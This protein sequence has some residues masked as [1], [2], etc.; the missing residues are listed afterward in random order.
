MKHCY[1]LF[2][3]S[4]V[5]VA[6][7]TTFNTKENKRAER[8][9]SAL[10][11]WFVFQ[12]MYPGTTV[13]Y[14]AYQDAIQQATAMK[15]FSP[16]TA[17]IPW[18]FA[19]PTN[20]GGRI[21]DIE[22]HPSSQQV[23]YFG[24]ASGGVFKSTDGGTTFN[25]IFDQN[26][27]LS[28]G[29]IAI[30]NTDANTIYV[31]TGEANCGGGSTTYDGMGIFKSTDG[32]NT[33][34]NMGLAQVR[35]VGRIA[36]N[37]KDKNTVY[38]AAMG[39]LYGKTPD[40]GVYKSTDGGNT[41]NNVLFINDSTGAVDIAVNPANPDTVF[42]AT[43][44]RVRTPARRNYGGPDCNIWRSYNGGNTW[45]KLANGLP[46][47][48]ATNGRIGLDIAPSSPNVLY[49]I[50]ADN[51]GSFKN[52]YKTIDNGNTWTT[53]N[54]S[55]L[56]GMY[57]TYGWWN[58]KIR[59]DPNNPNI[60]FAVGFDVY[61]TTNG[62]NNWS[63]V[64]NG[65]HVDH[66][67][68]YVHPANSNL[69][70]DANDGGFYKSTNGGTSWN[71]YNSAPISQFYACDID[72]QNPTHLYGGLQ[73]NGVQYTPTGALNNWTSIF[74][75]DGFYCLVD[76]TNNA[77]VYCESQYGNLNTSMN[78]IG[79]SDRMNWCTPLALNPLNPSSVYYGSQRLYKSLNKSASWNAISPDL[80]N[81][82]QGNNGVVFGTLT[83]ISVSPVD[84]NI[85]WIGTDDGN[86]RVTTNNGG[87][88]ANVSSGLP[89]RWITRVAADLSAPGTAYVTV[90]GYKWDDFTPHVFRT[91][92]YGATWTSISSNLP[93]APANDII[94]DPTNS[95]Q[96]FVAT[97]VGV[98][99][100]NNLGASWQLIGS[101]MPIVP[102]TDICLHN[103]TR[104][105]VAATFGRSMYKL[106]LLSL[107]QENE[108]AGPVSLNVFP[109]PSQGE[110]K[111]SGLRLP[112][113][114]KVYNSTG[115][116]VANC[117]L[118]TANCRLS[119]PAGVYFFQASRNGTLIGTGKFVI[120]D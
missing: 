16:N 77:N 104:T 109:N 117:Q 83:T 73:D 84:T 17:A 101:G 40:R 11:D 98:Y 55:S 18:Q 37:P 26:N 1:A 67:S 66:H 29:D 60:V 23:I 111:V 41:W 99:Y 56:S 6:L 80:T 20:I 39:D 105:L 46:A 21:T 45:T 94:I 71:K 86:V 85:I 9:E 43:W 62:G 2:F 44:T 52:I 69:V 49:T 97:D 14:E 116:L 57:S 103:P 12:R 50:Y 118:L 70:L 90:S 119:L 54:G 10:N 115:G 27:S 36:V 68:V 51:I 113:D 78:G 114:L 76:P 112:A 96:L 13:D 35:N 120:S 110:F 63:G 7:L 48:S 75:G 108:P 74:G 89:V 93:L 91:A 34:A 31:G 82:N 28:I 58:G 8:G 88:W 107:S 25:P 65:V 5:S 79:G 22:M 81:G 30:A 92:N 106:N 3:A 33:W 61:R 38:A 42:A 59:I 19:G 53:V 15:N 32:G 4:L 100:T 72:F 102:V 95:Q 24:A 47:N 87:S 64:T